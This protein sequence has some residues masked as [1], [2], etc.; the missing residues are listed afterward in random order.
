MIA[1][2]A[3]MMLTLFARLYYVQLLDPDK[4]QQSAH[5]THDAKIVI[6]AP[7]GLIVDAN[8]TPLVA[9][10]SVQQVT[11]TR[12]VLQRRADKG[13][14]VLA[15]LASLLDTSAALLA[16]QITPCS[17][18]VPAPCSTGKPFAPVTVSQRAP[19][20]VVLAISEHREDYP[21]V[22]VQTVS[23][24]SYPNASLAA[25]LLGYT[26]QITAADK[27][28]N[29]ALDDV[30][31]IG[32][33]GLEEQYDAALRGIDGEQVVRLSPQGLAV[34][35]GATTRAQQG[36]TLVTSI[37]GR[38]QAL[39]EK[40][41]AQQIKDSRKAGKAAPSG[42]VVIMD[43]QTGRIVA[44]ASYPTYDPTVFVGGVSNREYA[45]LTSTAANTPLLNRAIAGQYAPG[46]TFKLITSS[47]LV[48]HGQ[49]NLTDRYGCPGSL[50]IDGRV[51]TNFESESLGPI[52]LRDALGYSCDTFFY[53]PTAGEYYA[54][55][56]RVAKDEKPREWLQAMARAYGVGTSPGV[57]LP[58]GEQSSGGYADRES[59]LARWKANR[60][61]YCA[62]GRRGY[63]EVKDA[64]QRAYLTLLAKEN[65]TDGWRYRAGDNADMSI[66]QGETTMSPLQLAAAYS[67]LVNGGRL[68]EPTLGKAVVDGH[69]KVVKSID[70]KVRRTVPVSQQTLDY[71]AR[72]L[73]FG[74]GYAVSG[75]FAYLKSGYKGRIGGKTGTAEVEGKQDTS[76]LASW[77]PTYS[78]GGHVRA[79]FV[80]VGMVEQAG[81]G[82][83]AAGPMLKRIWDGIFGVG[84]TPVVAHERPRTTLPK[85]EAGR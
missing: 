24:P 6:P 58:A 2:V 42:A 30:D 38:L 37:D 44:S 14:A 77:G 49:I 31:T 36:D 23:V 21:G 41:L 53:R 56:K 32:V 8:G 82:A 81:T 71:I 27:S 66:G 11:V 61:T 33:S 25:H 15:R 5:L 68:F 34:G 69:G 16:K 76:W 78:K 47:S 9:N 48:E 3:S 50:T 79:R 4:P 83:T 7:R 80:M 65:C 85:V 63:P 74:R 55:Q 51:K 54:D 70:A 67:A 1:L 57:D 12:D 18:K 59:R 28:R 72:S 10:T 60:A 46:S 39:A 35:T 45:K 62:N 52:D 13:R 43:P 19:Q 22:A 40:S 64:K 20:R 29:S 73:N 26:S 84:S 17:P 75:A